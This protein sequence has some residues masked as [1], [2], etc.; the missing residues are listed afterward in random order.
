MILTHLQNLLVSLSFGVMDKLKILEYVSLNTYIK[1]Y[2]FK[3][4]IWLEPQDKCV[5]TKNQ[6]K[7]AQKKS[8]ERELITSPAHIVMQADDEFE[9]YIP[10]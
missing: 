5:K 1:F 8:S 7:M 9:D 2:K 4:V 3:V 6:F 10:L